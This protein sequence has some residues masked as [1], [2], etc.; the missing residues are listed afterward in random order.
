MTAARPIQNPSATLSQLVLIVLTAGLTAQWV[1]WRIKLPAIVLLI[2]SGLILGPITGVIPPSQSPADLNALIGLG[3]AIILFEGGMDLKLAELRRTGHGVWRLLVLGPPVAWALG[4]AAAHYVAG[5]SWP[6]SIV[7]GAILV[8]TGPTVILP[9]LRQARLNKDTASLLKWEG[10]VNDPTGVLLAVLSFQYFTSDGRT[11]TDTAQA[12]GMALA[13]G[14]GIGGV[15]GW[16]TGWLYRR[17]AVPAHLKA[18]ILMVLVLVIY[19][20]S[21]LVQHEAGLLSVTVMGM[22]IGNMK[23]VEREALQRFKESLT[24]LLLSVLFIVI[25]AQL[26]PQHLALINFRAVLFVLVLMFLVRPVTIFAATAFSPIPLN[27]RKLLAWIAPRG[28]VAA[29]T[30]GLFGP[31]LVDAGYADADRLLPIVFLVI[32]ITVVAHG[33]TIGPLAQRLKLAADESN[34]L[35]IVGASAFSV[36]LAQTLKRLNISVRIVDGVFGHLKSARMSGVPVYYGEILSEE[37]DHALD[38]QNLSHLLCATENDFYN[39]LVCK[40]KVRE[41]GHHRTFQLVTHGASQQDFKRMAIETR[42]YF[43]F[44]RRASY[45]TLEEHAAEGWTIQSTRISRNYDWD[46]MK[47]RLDEAHAD[48]LLLAGVSPKGLFRLYSSEQRFKLEADWTAI[49]FAPVTAKPQRN[50]GGKGADKR[51]AEV[52]ADVATDVAA[53]VAVDVTAKAG[54]EPVTDA[55]VAAA[56]VAAVAAGASASTEVPLLAAPVDHRAPTAPPDV[57]N[58]AAPDAAQRNGD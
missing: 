46:T 34:G 14:G 39:A 30:A 52:P 40:A 57:S 7:L 26:G 1:A 16:L 49:Y 19:W 56:A 31:A 3:V 10:I 27:D 43:A 58:E 28:I 45:A 13:V 5:L 23:L 18:P 51:N 54:A 55:A 9:L 37:V 47:R 15:G 41:F 25:P 33:L 36:A 2:A 50:A 20:L 53:D 21:N 42:G 24:V 32:I 11:V 38:T 12:L 17:G 22:V 29:A 6:V 48:W 4:S 44:S 35:L 8:V